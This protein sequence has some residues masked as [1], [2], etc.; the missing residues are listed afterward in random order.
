MNCSFKRLHLLLGLLYLVSQTRGQENRLTC[1]RRKVKSVYLIHNGIDAKAGHWPWHAAIFHQQAGR[2]DYACGGSILDENTILTAS[3]CV[4]NPRGVLSTTRVAVHVGRINLK[5]A[6][7]YTQTHSVLEIVVHPMFSRSSIINDIALIKLSTNITMTKYVQP[8]C[9]WTMDSNQELIVGRNGTIVGFGLNEQ[10]VVSDQLKQALIGVADALTCIASDR[11]VFGTHLTS[12]IFCGKGQADVSACNGDSGGGMFFEVGGKWFVRGLVSFTP[13]RANTTLCDPHKHTAYTDVAKHL[14][15]IKQ[16]I[17]NRVLSFESDV[18]DIDY[19]EKLRLFNFETC[20]IKSSTF[21]NDGTRWTLPWLGFVR[22]PKEHKSRCAVTLISEWY[23][24]GPALCFEN[25]GVEAFVLLGNGIEHPKVECFDRNGT[26]DCTHPSQIRRIQRIIVHPRF[27]ANNSA[28]NIALIELLSPADTSQPNVKPICLPV[29]S[30]LRTS[31]TTNLHVATISRTED[32]YINLPVRYLEPTECERQYFVQKIVLKLEN[33]RLCAEIASKQDE[34]NCDALIAGAPLQEAKTFSGTERYFLR[35]FELLGL[36]CNSQAPTVYNNAEAYLDW[37]LYNMR[38]NEPDDVVETESLSGNDTLQSQWS[39]LQQEPGNEKLRLFNMSSCGETKTISSKSGTAVFFPWMVS[40]FNLEENLKEQSDVSVG[41]VG[42]LISDRYFL[43]NAHLVRQKASWRSAV[44]GLYNLIQ[45]SECT[46]DSCVKPLE[47]NIRKITVHPNYAKDPRNY[48]IALV[49]L[50]EPANHTYIQPICMPF[51]KE[52]LLKSVPLNLVVTSNEEFDMRSK[53][54]TALT[55]TTC[56]RQLAQEGFLTSAKTVPWCAVDGDIRGQSAL[57]LNGGAPLQALLKFDENQRY[58]LRGINLRNNVSNEFPYLPEMFTNVDRFIEWVV[59]NMKFK[60]TSFNEPKVAD[61]KRV[62]LP[63]IRNGAKSSLVD[64]NNCGIIPPTNGSSNNRPTIPWMGYLLTNA[65]V[66]M[67]SK[68]AITLISEWYAVGLATCFADHEEEYSALFGVNSVNNQTS[69]I[70]TATECGASSQRIPVRKVTIHPQ[71]DGTDFS[72]DIA[73]LQLARAVDT[74]QPTITPICL[75]VLDDVRSYDTSSMVA[76]AENQEAT[77]YLIY[78]AGNRYIES[79]ECQKLWDDLAVNLAIENGKICILLEIAPNNECYDLLIGSSLQTV[80]KIGSSERHFLRGIV[81]IKARFCTLHFPLV[82]TNTDHHLDWLLENMEDVKGPTN[83]P[84]LSYDLREKLIFAIHQARGQENHLTCGRR[85]VKSVYLIHNGIDAKAGHWPW[86]VAIFHNKGKQREYACGGAIVDE[87]TILTAAHCIYTTNGVVPLN[88]I[89]VHLGLL[90]LKEENEFTQTHSLQEIIVH[91]RYS[92][93]SII[94]DIALI[95]LSTNITMT[96][97]VQPVCLW[98][99]DSNQELIVGR[100]GTIVGFGLSE[101]D[102]VSD[103]LK[104][105]LIGVADALTCIASDRTVFGT[106]LTSEIFCGKGQADVSACNGDSGGG[107]FFE[108]GGK[109][110]V[111]GLV[112]FTPLRGNTGLCNPQKYTAYTD[113]AKHLEWISQ[114]IDQR[115]LSFE[116][117]VL[118]IDYDEKLRLF[119]FDTCGIKSSTVLS[120]GS[121]WTLPWLGFVI[122]SGIAD[123]IASAR[124]VVTLISDWYAIGPAHCFA[125]DGVERSILLGGTSESS[126]SECINRNG[127][128][129]C[130]HPTQTLRIERIITHPKYDASSFGNNIVLIELLQAANTS[131]PNVKPICISAIPELRASQMT[132]LSVA[133]YSRQINSYRTQ[134]VNQYNTEQCMAQYADLGLTVSWKNMRFCAQTVSDGESGCVSLRSGAPLQELRSFGEREHYFLR[135]FEVFGLACASETP[136]VYNNIDAYLDWI[137]Y[138][139]RYN[140]VESVDDIRISTENTTKQTIESEWSKLQQQPGKEQL[141]LFDMDTCGITSTRVENLGQIT[142]LPWIGFFQ[143]AENVTDEYSSTR[144]LVVLISEWYALTPKRSVQERVTWRLVILGKYNPD[145]PTNCYTST[146]GITHQMVEIKN[147]IIPPPDYPRQ[148]FALLELLEPANLKIPFIRP[149]CLPFMEQLYRQNPTEVV[150]SSNKSFTIESKKLIMIDYLNCQQR[151]LL[152]THFVTFDGDFPCAIEAEKLRQ[153]PLSSNLGSPLQMPVRYGGRTRYFLYGVDYNEPHIFADLVY[154]PYLFG[155]VEMADL[156][157]IVENMRDKE[158]QTSFLTKKKNERV[159]LKP[160]QH[161]SK[162]GWFNFNIC[163]ESSSSYPMPWIGNVYPKTSNVSKCSV[164]LISEW[165]V[166]GPTYCFDDPT[167]Q[168]IIAFGLHSDTAELECRKANNSESCVLPVQRIVTQK[169][170]IHPQHNRFHY[171]N[172]IALAQLA[173]PVDMSHANV[174]PICLPIIDAVRS[175]DIS[176]LAMSSTGPTSSTDNRITNVDD[177]Y[178]DTAECQKR[179]QG[180]S[181]SF[182]VDSSKHCVIAQRSVDDKCVGVFAGASLHS[183]HRVETTDRHFLRG[184]NVILPRGCSVY[185]PLVYTNTDECLG[186]IFETMEQPA[187]LTFDLRKELVF[188]DK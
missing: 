119:N 134:D 170:F 156:D 179:W 131:K 111:R 130:T 65:T 133:S 163:G 3:H 41:S 173:K 132:N 174:K 52:W 35:G 175:Y 171:A 62:D 188:T 48:N 12:E 84:A 34:Q 167:Q 91:P 103:Q 7:E 144:S 90:N 127:T 184:F 177:R 97:Y 8:V 99:M 172:E 46:G 36:A 79:S 32:S 140:M 141:R 93:V 122:L 96:K 75:P 135:G 6:S 38:Y 80:Q 9:L 169:I 19:D 83:P 76:V 180:L 125:N 30:E 114:Y 23:A 29:T 116:S 154:G 67:P 1:G 57:L 54:L 73:L 123:S 182:T 66:D 61:P 112:S 126:K 82:Y 149:I 98:T 162:R 50:A 183:L 59:E 85:K 105:A 33:K 168:H 4:H 142:I 20:G 70:G 138:N 118:D 139:M 176:S 11:A 40:V 55:P 5:E 102:V 86:H 53:Q 69:C 157:W 146:C 89:S 28:D 178:L 136:P 165:Y 88:Q 151:L 72:Y 109:W 44:I 39:R 147:V 115:V 77:H 42:V 43:T 26:T 22:A 108:V 81:E 25:D 148:V 58:F 129:K 49:E 153:I 37:I 24:V 120:D 92:S 100:N 64:F 117:D 187:G 106:H 56:Q 155:T 121:S 137:L 10:D 87:N 113:V 145:D 150:I 13:L 128:T 27:G 143:A 159:I 15:W 78:P 74:S 110:F 160:F 68:C 95:K 31:A 161:A 63:P 47:L 166:V 152:G 124:C 186:W 107:M 71:Y 2:T 101:R 181:V 94:N 158:L 185:Y 16:Y 60:A 18:L 21:V 17:D 51:L 104:Q 45:Q 14:E 164:T